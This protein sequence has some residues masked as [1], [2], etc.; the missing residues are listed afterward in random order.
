MVCVHVFHIFIWSNVSSHPADGNSVCEAVFLMDWT[1]ET[2]ETV[3]PVHCQ[4]KKI[5]PDQT[6]D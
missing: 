2:S 1:M 5:H 4:E 3:S 6:F